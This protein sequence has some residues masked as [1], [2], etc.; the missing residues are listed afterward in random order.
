MLNGFSAASRRYSFLVVQLLFVFV[1][2]AIHRHILRC[3]SMVCSYQNGMYCGIDWMFILVSSFSVLIKS[4]VYG[5]V[6]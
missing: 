3:C 6:G 2:S 5:V 4:G 1:L